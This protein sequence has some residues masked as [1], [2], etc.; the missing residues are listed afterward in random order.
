[1]TIRQNGQIIAGSDINSQNLAECYVVVETWHSDT[2]WYRVWSDG[3]CEQG[4]RKERTATGI[5]DV[6]L[7]KPFTNLNYN[8]QA[9]NRASESYTSASTF[10]P[11]YTLNHSITGF[12]M[13]SNA[14]ISNIKYFEWV[15][16][17]FIS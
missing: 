3:W 6:T 5:I 8:V 9:T 2:E 14:S 16:Y 4:G 11:P 17:G 13:S 10:Y 7:L 1:M 15:A 12:S